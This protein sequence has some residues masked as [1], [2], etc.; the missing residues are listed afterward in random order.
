MERTKNYIKNISFNDV[1]K[2][3]EHFSISMNSKLSIIELQENIVVQD[4]F[5]EIR[6]R[7]RKSQFDEIIEDLKSALD[8]FRVQIFMNMKTLT[9]KKYDIP[10]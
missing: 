7:I 2:N 4:E 8:N 9:T 3:A 1:G 10:S 6:I 5:L